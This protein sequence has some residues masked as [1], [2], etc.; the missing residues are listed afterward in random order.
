MTRNGAII[1]CTNDH[2][3]VISEDDWKVG[4]GKCLLCGKEIECHDG[5]RIEC[6]DGKRHAKT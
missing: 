6:D 5:E 1:T 2:I 4:Y 3:H